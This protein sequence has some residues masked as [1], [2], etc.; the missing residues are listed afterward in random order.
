MKEKKNLLVIPICAVMLGAVSLYGYKTLKENN[1][2]IKQAVIDGIQD[3]QT[4][5]SS[6]ASTENFYADNPISYAVN[7][8]NS[9]A[10]LSGYFS[11]S[12]KEEK[13]LYQSIVDNADK[14][15]DEMTGPNLYRIE[16]MSVKNHSLDAYQIRKV[17]YAVKND[18]PEF[19]WFSSTFSYASG[20]SGTIL[21]LY[22]T[23]PKNEQKIALDKLNKKIFNIISQIPES[24]SEY[25]KELFIHDYLVDNCTYEKNDNNLKVFTAY[26]CLID[27]KA[28]CEGYSK[29]AQLLLCAAGIDCRPVIG[30]RDTEDHMWNVVKI[31]NSWYHIDVTWDSKDELNKYNYFNLTDDVIRKDHSIST[32]IDN[33]PNYYKEKSYNFSLP[34]CTS[35]NAN[36]FEKNAVKILS[37]NNL[38]DNSIPNK[39]IN[40]R[41]H[42]KSVLYINISENLEFEN[43]KN[44]LFKNNSKLIFEHIK[45]A[46]SQL[47]SNEKFSTSQIRT[48]V[49]EN[50]RVLAV[51]LI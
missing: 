2:D 38:T 13:V 16:T 30:V 7:V 24:F 14:I 46:N 37:K 39:I 35:K 50:S 41:K 1:Y 3:L 17:L 29:A 18:H 4:L 36:Y 49:V 51:Q 34:R 19:F 11:L 32:S 40:L 21:K 43:T 15:T 42:G 9:V 10:T 28:V 48:A 45:S 22:S 5:Q 44:E 8:T 33:N 31:G 27:G 23:F 6:S 26:G 12:T 20:D 25:E 47:D